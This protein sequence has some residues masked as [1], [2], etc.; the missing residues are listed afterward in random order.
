LEVPNGDVLAVFAIQRGKVFVFAPAG[1]GRLF[2]RYDA[3]EVRRIKNPAAQM[4]GS[5]KRNKKERQS[6]LKQ[7][8]ARRNGAQPCQPGKE[9]GR[10]RKTSSVYTDLLPG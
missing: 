9:R 3:S 2:D 4:M 10:P 1:S 8:S 5:L 6:S 7:A